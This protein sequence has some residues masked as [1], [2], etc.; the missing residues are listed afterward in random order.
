VFSD[1]SRLKEQEAERRRAERIASLEAIASGLVHEIRN[2]LVAIKTFS[3]LLP[4][5]FEDAAFREQSARVISRQ[6]ERIDSLLMRFRTLAAPSSAPMGVL[7]V[8][9][10]IQAT[11]EALGPRL[12]ADRIAVRMV[13][14]SMA[15]PIVGNASRL[16][17]LFGN[18]CLNAIDAMASGGELT[19]RIADPADAIGGALVVEIADTGPGIPEELLGSIF[20]PFVTTKAAGTGLGLAIC[21]SI[22][23]AHC[24]T[25]RARNNPG[26][27]GATF[28]IEFPIQTTRSLKVSV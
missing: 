26:L 17:Q 11:L 15:R 22:A 25:L 20:D 3:Q 5:R 14:D 7:D 8:R 27:A 24:A 12:E 21:R 9:D 1:L 23:D 6:V 19:V 13:G 2:P 16:E 28:T 18:L 4:V 10:P